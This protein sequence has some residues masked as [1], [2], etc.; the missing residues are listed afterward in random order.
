LANKLGLDGS[1]RGVMADEVHAKQPDA[2]KVKD[3]FL[4]VNY[5]TLG[6]M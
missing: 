1:C 4:F 6:V 3:G 5:S 2:V